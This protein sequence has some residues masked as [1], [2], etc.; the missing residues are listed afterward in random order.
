MSHLV[1]NNSLHILLADSVSVA[2]GCAEH[3]MESHTTQR[4]PACYQFYYGDHPDSKRGLSPDFR[5]KVLA[6]NGQNNHFEDSI[7]AIPEDS[8]LTEVSLQN[9]FFDGS[10][11]SIL[12]TKPA[13]LLR[14]NRQRLP[15]LLRLAQRQ[16]RNNEQW[17]AA[18]Q[19]DKQQHER[20]GLCSGGRCKW[21]LERNGLCRKR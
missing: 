3:S 15:Q 16:W 11:I 10:R 7:P 8:Q 21:L 6:G 18:I 9:Q 14:D 12:P 2:H 5:A 1:A 4:V 17:L 20:H 13:A 19:C